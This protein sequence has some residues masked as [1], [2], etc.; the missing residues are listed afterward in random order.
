MKKIFGIVVMASFVAC[1][2]NRSEV[3]ETTEVKTAHAILDTAKFLAI[4]DE[5]AKQT[6]QIL[7]ANVANAIKEKG[8]AGAVDFCNT[9]AVS[10]TDSASDMFLAQISRV[11]N[12][13]RNPNN[14]LNSNMDKTAWNEIVLMM[15]DAS[16][17]DK[18][19]IIQ[20][21]NETY[22]FKA[23]PIGMPTCL[24]CHGVVGQDINKETYDVIQAK[25]PNDKATGYKMG[26]LRG[27]WKI[28]LNTTL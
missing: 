2:S 12:L 24:S 22:Y 26:E 6:Q 25:Y 23:I 28:K 8:V 9:R 10:L 4:G 19:I 17:P 18:H 21:N 27:L 13:N 5:M 14:G 20:E 3:A 16:L 15:S 11:S 1:S 7:L